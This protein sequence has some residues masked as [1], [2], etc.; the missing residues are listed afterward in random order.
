MNG[1]SQYLLG[2]LALLA[3]FSY[4]AQCQDI[5]TTTILAN[6]KDETTTEQV[7]TSNPTTELTAS[8]LES[9]ESSESAEEFPEAIESDDSN[10]EI[11]EG[12]LEE[13]VE[14][15]LIE[16]GNTKEEEEKVCRHELSGG[17]GQFITPNFPEEYNQKT[18]CTWHIQGEEGQKIVLT[19]HLFNVENNNV[20]LWDWVKVFDSNGTL[21]KHIC[22]YLQQDLVIASAGKNMSVQ[23]YSDDVVN[24]A[25]FL[26]SWKAVPES[27]EIAELKPNLEKGYLLTFPQSFTTSK[28]NLVENVCLQMFNVES[29]GTV[30]VGLY[31]SENILEGVPHSMGEFKPEA[32]SSAIQ[33]LKLGLP[34]SFIKGSA[35]MKVSGEF[36]DGYKIL[37]YKSV[38]ALNLDPMFLVQTDKSDY[39]PK[40]KVFFRVLAMN[41][42]LKPSKVETIPEIWITDPSD[43]RLAQWKDVALQSGFAQ[44]DMEL[45]EEPLLGQW[46]IH[47]KHDTTKDEEKF[48]FVVSE[49][50][51]PKFEV[52]L[53]APNVMIRDSEFHNF[54]LCAKYTHG[55]NVKGL[56]NITFFSEFKA[57]NYWRAPTLRKEFNKIV[58]KVEEGC[59]NFALNQSEIAE[60]T[61]KTTTIQAFAAFIEDVTQTEHN[62]TWE[63]KVHFSPFAIEFGGSAEDHIV[64]QFPYVGEIFALK[65]DKSPM[66]DT[67]VEVCINL[68]T[69]LS[70][71]RD[72]V[73]R[74]SYLFYNYEE[75]SYYE[76]SEK[77]A[78]I[79]FG[80]SCSNLT[81]DS[82]GKVKISVPIYDIPSNITKLSI[83]VA[84]LDHPTNETRGIVQPKG[85]LD[86]L[87]SH[88]NSTNALTISENEINPTITCG[89][90]EIKIY[91]AGTPDTK[92][93]LNYYVSSGGA[94]L[95]QGSEELT[96]SGEDLEQ[97]FVGGAEV[98][99]FEGE[100]KPKSTVLSRHDVIIQRP[101][102]DEAL[103]TG[104]LKLL[105]F[106][107]DEEGN[108]LTTTKE[109]VAESCTDQPSA[110]WSKPELRPGE[111]VELKIHGKPEAFC[112]YSV[113]DKSVDLVPNENKITEPRVEELKEKIAMRR[114]VNDKNFGEGCENANLLFKAFER[115][116][117]F[118]LS[119]QLLIST[120]CDTLNDVTDQKNKEDDIYYRPRPV[121]IIQ[122]G[123]FFDDNIQEAAFMKA[124]AAP[125]LGV[126]F[127][128]APQNLGAAPPPPPN[129]AQSAFRPTGVP[130]QENEVKLRDYF[131]ETWLFEMINLDVE[132][133]GLVEVKAP[134][135][136]T[137]WIAEV[138]CMDR[139]FGLGISNKSS[140][141]VSQDFFADINMPYSVKRGEILPVNISVFNNVE[142]PLPMKLSLQDSEEFKVDI[143]DIGVCLAGQDNAIKTFSI[144]AKELN[145]VNITVQALIT[146]EIEEACDESGE[147]E[148]FTDMLVKSILVKPEGFPV[149]KVQSQFQCKG[150]EDDEKIQLE[151]EELTLPEDLVE[152]SE[153]AWFMVTGDIMAPSLANLESL[154]QLPTGC[155]EQ[156]MIGM[157][158]NVYLLEYMK[159]SGK[160]DPKL[161]VQAKRNMKTGF[162]REQK[163]RHE[164]GS[165][166]VW[167][168][169]DK[170]GSIWL[171][172]F[173]TK[174]F[175]QAT[176][177]VE[178]DM[179]N[180]G[181][182]IQWI[183]TNQKKDGSFAKTGYVIHDELSGTDESLTASVLTTLLEALNNGLGAE[184]PLSQL[185][186]ALDYVKSNVTEESEVYTKSVATYALSLFNSIKAKVHPKHDLLEEPTQLLDQ[187]VTSANTSIPG[188]LFW[189]T[190]D[191][192]R[193]TA[194]EI[195]AYNVLSLTLQD[196]LPEALKAIRWL[197]T[198]RNSRGGFVSTQDTVVALQAMSQY[199]LKVKNEENDLKVS[200]KQGE[201]PAQEMA[202]TNDNLLLLQKVKLASLPA[203]LETEITGTGCFMFQTVLRYNVK[204][205]PEKN[206]FT[207]TAEVEDKKA[208]KVCA[209][210]IGD[211]EKTDMVVI[212]IELLSG[213]AVYRES[214]EALTNEIEAPIKRY[215]Y[216]EE[217][218]H[219]VLYFD[220]MP[221]NEACWIMELKQV[222][223]IEELKPALVKIYDYYNQEDKVSVDYNLAAS[224]ATPEE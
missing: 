87:L 183:L 22:G 12:K 199:S 132:G 180:I 140:V 105:M 112:G 56:A 82:N 55:G 26:A 141:L 198:Q 18:N 52:T 188:Q 171:S 164:D 14:L 147:A 124:E 104:K 30:Q 149:E 111:V 122:N 51:L 79:R 121:P 60:L 75:D 73:N 166:S 13:P 170:V 190:K 138:V 93:E 4:H 160:A 173:V 40:Q 84:S 96:V 196:K 165:Y 216:D 191:N 70:E 158:P 220:T 68:F 197:A 36:E 131:P 159:G 179:Q 91:F 210:Y 222:T 146:S 204:E 102:A 202:L 206:S 155:G 10:E 90:N 177:F 129:A 123:D 174:V 31:D 67:T 153:R 85:K 6:T 114:V 145:E 106:T 69:S 98:I 150:A 203:K 201:E 63:D 169:Q 32:G 58:E 154:V 37:S 208:L 184:V 35:I 193:A 61:N 94:L 217:K 213:F 7:V 115:L 134:H 89:K 97:E 218:G 78:T 38:R 215:D 95:F 1:C 209:A 9:E 65:H 137:K 64:G 107:R 72:Y 162:E 100:T 88:S 168:P 48:T 27:E 41:Y 172:S 23:F 28:E 83:Q 126:A 8:S 19:F 53:Q 46:T 74:N 86:V 224:P 45:S 108:I 156:N 29:T 43:A 120:T 214:L 176:Q 212:E 143:K 187:L 24:S 194:V 211:K 109:F 151:L 178:L 175:V 167:G 110:D 219:V 42:E 66:A 34:S 161:E 182:T 47:L 33:C 133:Q 223:V 54:T 49:N 21:L 50:V 99:T 39:R 181:Q 144:Q 59:A 16:D 192:S 57:G 207:L 76:L 200:V 77:L 139:V 80:Q 25:G 136:I 148:G 101:F 125:A 116:G 127:D 17:S 205:S 130:V 44:M 157:A 2:I 152:G 11:D 81:T 135:T 92:L 118:I 3:C 163:F 15:V 103:V 117:L 128:A 195:T 71:M 189:T 20:C 119:D 5:D 113:V 185:E 62:T 186:S 221:K 142:R